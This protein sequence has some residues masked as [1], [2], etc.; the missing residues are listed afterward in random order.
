MQTGA[1]EAVQLPLGAGMQLPFTTEQFFG[2]F[3]EYNTALY[4]AQFL[5]FALAVVATVLVVFPRRWS[6][7]GI[8]GILAVLW[9]WLGI[10]YH[11]CFFTVI[12][13]LAYGFAA[14]SLAG[15][16]A[17]LW[18]GVIRRKLDFRMTRER[19]R[20][21]GSSWLSM[22]W[23]FTRRGPCIPGTP[24]LNCRPSGSPVR[25]RYS[26][27]ACLRSWSARIRV[28]RLSFRLSGPPLVTRPP[29]CSAY[30]RTPACLWR[31]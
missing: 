4:P 8:S 5:L 11:L 6:G 3:R 22:R 29:F 7:L 30:R 9:A 1:I 20:S 17:F 28:A 19:T 23:Q 24:I 21:S 10:A 31:W 16:F 13:P 27:W 26:P 2:V 15:S 14:L 12:N 25:R 18:Q